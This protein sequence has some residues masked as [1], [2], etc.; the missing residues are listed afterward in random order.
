[1]L[2]T[3]DNND[4]LGGIDY[5]PALLRDAPLAITRQRGEWARCTGTLD[6]QGTPLPLP[7]S[8]ALVLVSDRNGATLFRGYLQLGASPSAGKASGEGFAFTALDSAWLKG[9]SPPADLQPVTAATH[10][11]SCCDVELVHSTIERAAD[12]ATDVTVVGSEAAAD[13][14]TELFRGDGTTQSFTLAH[15]PF[16]ESGTTVL[17]DDSFDDPLLNTS[18]WTRHDPG[19]YLTLGAGG[20]RMGGGNGMDG[21]TV[22]QSASPV[23][24]GGT[25]VAEANGV[26][27]TT[28]SDGLLMGFYSTGVTH[29]SCTAGVR[30][31][32]EAGAHTLQAVVNGVESGTPYTFSDGHSYVVR[33]RLHCGEMQRMRGSYAALVDG[34]LQTFGG[35]IVSAPLHIVIEALDLGLASSTLATVL[36]DGAIAASPPQCIFAPVNATQ[37]SGSIARVTLHQT[38]SAWVV[39]TATDGTLTTRRSGPTGTGADYALS[40]TG[41]L[42]FDP[43]R[44]PQPGELLTVSYRR[45]SQSAARRKDSASDQAR[46]QLALPGLPA[47]AG[48]VAKPKPRS[49][50]DCIAAA[51]ALLALA[52]GNATSQAGQATWVRGTATADDVQPGDTLSISSATGTQTLPVHT[53]TLTDGNALPELVTIRA[54]FAQSRTASLSFTVNNS[55]PAHL[56][57]P[58]SVTPDPGSLPA[59]LAGLQVTIAT[60]SA[61][62]VDSGTDPPANGGFEVRR[63]N[64]NF[65]SAITADLVL[66]SLVRSFSIPRTA[67]AERFFVRMYDGSTP[68]NYSA[69]SSEVLTS[70]PLS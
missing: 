43:G 64:A 31:H 7:S 59:T 12:L 1:M 51:Q 20:L 40:S 21:A 67:F 29:D 14:V 46:L 15:A 60:G 25:L 62:Q 69:V 54:D 3:I 68:P 37:L 6:L 35:G 13:Y 53:V 10:T 9:G 49:R 47:W 17:L 36:F 44:V 48:T 58:V 30:V 45:S 57:L 24:L 4:G 2:L 56:S 66:Q 28:G 5:S 16:R 39:S 70:L 19:S 50:E 33:V 22:L 38:G 55:P 26:L 52:T 61:L 11:L 42:T 41:V 8:R 23:E 34:T 63:S 18:V 65:G 27:L 32:G